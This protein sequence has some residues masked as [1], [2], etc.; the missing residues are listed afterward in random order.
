[1]DQRDLDGSPLEPEDLTGDDPSI[2]ETPRAGVEEANTSPETIVG[3]HEGK[4]SDESSKISRDPLGRGPEKIKKFIFL[5]ED[6][7]REGED[8][9]I[10]TPRP[11]LKKERVEEEDEKFV[12]EVSNEPEEVGMNQGAS[13]SRGEKSKK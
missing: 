4:V 9:E 3:T 11:D 2:S 8:M 10:E 12:L 1:M 6:T 7:A 13:P 5:G